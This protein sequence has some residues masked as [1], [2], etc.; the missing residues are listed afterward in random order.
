MTMKIGEKIDKVRLEIINGTTPS[1]AEDLARA[2]VKAIFAGIG[3]WDAAG[4]VVVNVSPEWT[5][6]MKLFVPD[7]AKE[8]ARLCGQ[9]KDFNESDWGL[10][11]LAYI[12]GDSTCTAPTAWTTGGKRSMIMHPDRDMIKN[13]DAET[14]D[15]LAK[16]ETKESPFVDVMK[17]STQDT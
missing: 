8:L 4:E 6:L 12:A 7:D 1:M 5:D 3:E 15:G 17:T 14:T 16:F 13:L 2:G 10:A 9:D 11:C